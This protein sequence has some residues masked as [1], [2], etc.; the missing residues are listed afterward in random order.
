LVGRPDE[1]PAAGVLEVAAG[2]GV[3]AVGVRSPA[4]WASAQPDRIINRPI[5][6]AAS[7]AGTAIKSGP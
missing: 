5:Q 2:M 7:R 3:G 1:G 6:A 4:G